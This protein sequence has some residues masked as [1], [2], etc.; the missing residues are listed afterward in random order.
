MFD[1]KFLILA[2]ACS[3]S[4]CAVAWGQSAPAGASSGGLGPAAQATTT[5]APAG[6][7]SLVEIVVTAQRR[8]ENLQ[9]VP[10]T[11]TAVSGDQL[12]ASGVQNTQDLSAVV[13]GLTFPVSQ[14]TALPH[15]RGVGNSAVEAGVENSVALYVDGVYYA[16]AAGSVL[17]L[18]NVAEVEVLKGP[19]GT[20][21][22]RNSTGGLIQITTKDPTQDFHG[23]ASV[24]YANYNTT[25][26]EGYVTGGITSALA[27]D[28]A[29]QLS[30]QGDGYGRNFATGEEAYQLDSN[31]SARSKFLWTPTDA[32]A[33]RLSL[34]YEKSHIY[35][36]FSEVPGTAASNVFYAQT[37]QLITLPPYDVNESLQPVQ[38]M[39][40]GGA[41]LRVT[42]DLGFAQLIDI[43]AYR[44][45]SFFFTVDVDLGPQPYFGVLSNQSDE[46]E[47]Q[48]IQL[49][50]ESSGKWHWTTG[51]YYFHAL[52]AA[53]PLTTTF[54][55]P[56]SPPV[57]PDEY[58]T[59]I[60]VASEQ[61]TNS[62]AG[63]G[64]ASYEI[65]P[66]TTLT[67]GVRLTHEVKSLEG[68]E[69]GQINDF[70]TVPFG[71]NSGSISVTKPTY[72]AS[73]D[74]KF[75]DDILGYVSYNQSFKSAGYNIQTITAP[76]YN[77]EELQ[78]Y[79]VGE[80]AQ[81]FDSRVRL[82]ASGFYYNYNN[83]QVVQ[84]EGGSA[85]VY[86]GAS[87][88]IFG[89]DIDLEVAVTRGLTLNAGV[90]VLRDYFTSFP[91]AEH[92]AGGANVSSPACTDSTVPSLP[93]QQSAA[94]NKLPY[95]PTVSA[96]I[97]LDYR[98][99]LFNGVGDFSI[100]D[101]FNSGYFPEPDNNLRQPAYSV[102]NGS[103]KWS[104]ANDRYFVRLWGKN[105]AN[106]LYTLQL[107]SSAQ[108]FSEAYAPPRTY[109]VT[110]GSNF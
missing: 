75:T 21:F 81:F 73:L 99:P 70:F 83:I 53:T 36:G 77:T 27:A 72:R 30:H 65:F 11:V 58:L 49:Q 103:I 20:L 106:K 66:R 97:G 31:I 22:G 50:S 32:T 57:G 85:T 37:P 84:F 94:G 25:S 8:S 101:A 68:R 45:T 13:P 91:C 109:G 86:N 29:I 67:L 62:I 82:N 55:G 33:V 60:T 100:D 23:D 69:T 17:S 35:S 1:G 88:R 90:E 19:Q 44:Q 52:D 95:T 63:Y 104:A 46:Q 5:A 51:L 80:K 38:N 92:F 54:S 39:E 10:I 93:Y 12:I 102:L 56:A 43:T 47:S 26:L 16:T 24:G 110:V 76:P 74:Y 89:S 71:S 42:Q 48:E 40:G 6:D 7:A 3:V 96:T 79:E 34:D 78:A 107:S 61:I 64:Q 9:N 41:S 18:N 98:L 2:V 14:G 59:Q 108:Q 28:L 105:L 4:I 87:A 15:L